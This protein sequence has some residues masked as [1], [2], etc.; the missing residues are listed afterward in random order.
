MVKFCVP[1]S[2]QTQQQRLLVTG[3]TPIKEPMLG[4]ISQIT[5]LGKATSMGSAPTEAIT[6]TTES[7]PYILLGDGR[8]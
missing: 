3:V 2:K 7:D 5:D 6:V 8:K 4:S 1:E